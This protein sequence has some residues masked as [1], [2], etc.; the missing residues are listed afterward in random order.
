MTS[1][2]R[3]LALVTA[4]LLPVAAAHATVRT[5]TGRTES[6]VGASETYRLGVPTEKDV[7]TTGVRLVVPAGVAITRFQVMPGFVRTVKTNADGLV[8][9]VTWRGRIAPQEYARFFFQARNPEQAG[10]LSWKVY[11][12][13]A[14][15]SVV[16]WDD[17][18]PEKTPASK[19]T[20]K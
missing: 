6:K 7:S 19:T 3:T 17:T 2:T 12:T 13:Y 14:D 15:G 8:T 9:E 1:L 5:E 16:A 18:D 4:L 11:Q 20:V 10:T